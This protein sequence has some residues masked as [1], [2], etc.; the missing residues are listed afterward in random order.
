MIAFIFDGRGADRLRVLRRDA[1]RRPLSPRLRRRVQAALAARRTGR[2]AYVEDGRPARWLTPRGAPKP[3]PS[4]IVPSAG[5][6]GAIA[7]HAACSAAAFAAIATTALSDGSSSATEPQRWQRPDTNSRAR[8]SS[9]R[10][11][12]VWPATGTVQPQPPGHAILTS[13]APGRAGAGRCRATLAGTYSRGP[14]CWPRYAPLASRQAGAPPSRCWPC[15][16]CRPS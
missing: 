2:V 11:V 5:R 3:G 4:A 7:R 9:A 8:P 10:H 15:T 6:T 1:D 12:H 14:S 13:G 16:R